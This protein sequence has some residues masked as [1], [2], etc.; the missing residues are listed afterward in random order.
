MDNERG[1]KHKMALR[2]R[3]SGRRHSVSHVQ[4]ADGSKK[5]LVSAVT[6]LQNREP[7]SLSSTPKVSTESLHEK[8]KPILKP[9]KPDI[10]PTV[11]NCVV[12]VYKEDE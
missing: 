10:D 7:S 11:A 8:P 9:P 3:Q 6:F 1:F 12:I 5:G 4:W 2:S